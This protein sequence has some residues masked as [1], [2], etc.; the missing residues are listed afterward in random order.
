M[1]RLAPWLCL[2]APIL[3]SA[4][5]SAPSDAGVTWAALP[6][7]YLGGWWKSEVEGLRAARK[8]QPMPG[9][10]FSERVEWDRGHDSGGASLLDKRRLLLVADGAQSEAVDKWEKGRVLVLCYDEA[11]GVTLLDPEGGLRLPVRHVSDRHPIEDYVRSL[12]AENT[13][14]LNA[15]GIEAIRL[16]RLEIDRS[17]REVLALPHL[18]AD[19]RARFIALTKTRLD[20]CEQQTRFGADAIA[21]SYQGGTIIGPLT[22]EYTGSVYRTAYQDL[23]R[24]YEQY[25]SFGEQTEAE[26]VGR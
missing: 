1:P 23:A 12:K 13:V 22:G 20:Y 17:V 9:C 24:L 7:D 10:L 26:K 6:A 14:Q 16:W 15:V 3:A 8:P 18:P 4:A 11:R 25:R 2:V 19:V 5:P 21:R